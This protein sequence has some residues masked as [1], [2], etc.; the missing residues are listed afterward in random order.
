MTGGTA[1]ELEP[2]NVAPARPAAT[3]VVMRPGPDGPEV[4]LTQRPAS[5]AFGPGLHVFPGG[6]LDPQD[7]DPRL[8]ERLRMS[9][10]E[11]SS[12]TG[13]FMVAAIREL[14][15]EAGVLLGSPRGSAGN[16]APGTPA[17]PRAGRSFLEG[18]V[19][20]DLELRGDWLVPMSRWVTPPVMARRFDARFFVTE[21][22]PAAVLDF[23]PGEVAGHAWMTPR[24][25]LGAMTDG[26]IALWPPTSTTLQQLAPAAGIADVWHYLTPS[27]AG[28]SDIAAAT[29]SIAPR[30]DRPVPSVACVRTHGAGAIGGQTV[31]TYLVGERR[32]AVV[33]PGDPSEAAIDLLLRLVEE[34]GGRISAVLLTAPVP[35]HAAGIESLAL[36]LSV[37]ILAAAGA[38]ALLA[39]TVES[40][41]D[42]TILDVADI[43]IRVHATPGT[44]PDHLAFELPATDAVLVGDLEGPGPA[45]AIPEPVDERL[46]RWSRDAVRRLHRASHLAAHD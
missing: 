9:G 35:D 3:V 17:S 16:A 44:H 6:G 36:R 5:M 34:R 25:A 40:L 45:R 21:L 43:A 11:P 24:A 46:V 2:R 28:G 8:L 42:G 4:L 30:V 27:P 18:I 31:N 10:A 22:P 38:R 39:S 32:V 20:S 1:P 26:R 15:E 13:A 12:H 19:N 7:S 29:M 41:D 33:D 23:D 14:Y 37:P